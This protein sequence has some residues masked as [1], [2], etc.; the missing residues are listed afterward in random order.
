[1]ELTETWAVLGWIEQAID[2]EG[3]EACLISYA[4]RFGLTALFAGWVPGLD[5]AARDI[6]SKILFQKFPTEWAARYNERNYVFRDPIVQRLQSDRNLF[7]W[8]DAYNSCHSSYDVNLI[9]GEASEFGLADGLVVPI[10]SVDGAHAAFSFGG[11]RLEISEKDAAALAFV[12]NF[13]AGHLLTIVSRR[14]LG[15]QSRL[16]PR[17]IDC[18]LWSAE[19]KTDWE[20]SKILGI[21]RPTVLKHMASARQKLGAMNKA[22]AVAMAMRSKLVR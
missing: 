4:A 8:A 22:H 3:I 18:L 16:T 5:I 11:E 9:R 10:Q 7:R 15:R 14:T 20:I 21:S 12:T 19:G 2:A 13:A 1:M 6:P 17:E